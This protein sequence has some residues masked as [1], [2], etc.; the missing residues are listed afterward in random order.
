MKKMF[1]ISLLIVS[2]TM[3]G[4]ESEKADQMTGNASES[5]DYVFK[6]AKV[7]T[8]NE[9]QPWAE[10]VPVKGDEIVYVGDAA[11]A[12]ALKGLTGQKK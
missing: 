4:C 6:N 9:S 8:V 5:A 12:E 2:V 10:M 3:S 7:Y 1:F 11:G